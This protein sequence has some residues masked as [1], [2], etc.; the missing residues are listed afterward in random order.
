MP[1][2]PE[3]MRQRFR[4]IGMGKIVVIAASW[5][6][7]TAVRSIVAGLSKPCAAS[8]FV[9]LH[10]GAL[11]TLLPEIL[12]MATTLPVKLAASGMRIEPGHIF[13]APS[14][15]H[16]LI[17]PGYIGLRRS[18]KVHHTRPAADPLFES[19]ANAYGGDVIGI[20]LTGGD[21][22]GAAGLRAIKDR[23]GLTIVQDPHE[24]EARGM[25]L[26]AIAAAQPHLCLRLADIGD[27]V[28]AL[29]AG[30]G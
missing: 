17:A 24:A 30:A 14:D 28:Q 10:I 16:M 26:A 27:C 9:V 18:P 1:E 13:V 3:P 20:V 15:Q 19:A 22:D 25:P 29:C 23:G 2:M 4:S 6:G 7:V 12:R 21:G 5:G 11:P 8:I